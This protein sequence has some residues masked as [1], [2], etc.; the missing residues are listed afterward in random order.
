MA[1]HA[2]RAGPPAEWPRL[3]TLPLCRQGN[4]D[5][6]RTCTL[7]RVQSTNAHTTYTHVHTSMY[8]AYI[9]RH[10]P[11]PPEQKP[12]AHKVHTHIAC[13]DGERLFFPL[14]EKNIKG[15][16]GWFENT[17]LF[18]LPKSLTQEKPICCLHIRDLAGSLSPHLLSGQRGHCGPLT[19]LRRLLWEPPS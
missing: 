5:A 18:W 3:Q 4:Q 11:R 1:E 2:H 9:C 17:S 14:R 15:R 6:I 12:P 7:M 8:T 16:S 10:A 13:L 19:A